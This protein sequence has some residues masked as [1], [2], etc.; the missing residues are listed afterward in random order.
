MR[1]P[2]TE[3]SLVANRGCL[4]RVLDPAHRQP[5]RPQDRAPE[6]KQFSEEAE[7]DFCNEKFTVSSITVASDRS[8]VSNPMIKRMDYSHYGLVRLFSIN[9]D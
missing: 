5:S 8:L 2:I 6:I 3:A 7:P 1:P 9:M 4:L